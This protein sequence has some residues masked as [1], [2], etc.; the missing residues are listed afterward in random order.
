M[1]EDGGKV[2]V[3]IPTTFDGRRVGAA[4]VELRLA[5]AEANAWG[6]EPEAR[7][8]A[9]NATIGFLHD[10]FPEMQGGDTLALLKR[11][12][13]DMMQ[14]I[15]DAQTRDGRKPSIDAGERLVRCHAIACVRFL[16]STGMTKTKA[17][18][19]VAAMLRGS[20]YK[21]QGQAL[22]NWEHKWLPQQQIDSALDVGEASAESDVKEIEAA[23]LGRWS[24][25]MVEPLPM[26]RR[27]MAGAIKAAKNSGKGRIITFPTSKVI[28]FP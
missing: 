6:N 9:L 11:Q 28:G 14:D 15:I 22:Q 20:P 1:G 26:V 27:V 4:Y 24:A 8:Q 23:L 13:D 19:E 2:A 21:A 10:A 12:R 3:D 17:R 7:L 5:L 16:Y 25:G 18:A